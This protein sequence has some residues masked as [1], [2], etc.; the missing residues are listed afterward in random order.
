MLRISQERDLAF[1]NAC[2]VLNIYEIE[3]RN[4]NDSHID[5]ILKL[6]F[7]IIYEETN[8]ED[9]TQLGNIVNAKNQI[10]YEIVRNMS[11]RNQVFELDLDLQKFTNGN[12]CKFCGGS[13]LKIIEVAGYI[14]NM[15]RCPDCLGTG[16]Q[17]KPCNNCHETGWFGGEPCNICKGKLRIPFIKDARKKCP[18]CYGNRYVDRKVNTGIILTFM[19]CTV[20]KGFGEITLSKLLKD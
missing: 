15:D 1:E 19:N 9:K 5:D 8:H 18:T 12:K 13:G 14:K 20:C 4:L 10:L 17:H 2:R 7:D 16:V 3:P 6:F 11:F